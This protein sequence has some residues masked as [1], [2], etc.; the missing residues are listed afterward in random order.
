MYCQNCGTE[1]PE[2]GGFCPECGKPVNTPVQ[3]TVPR[4][5]S[6]PESNAIN[7]NPKPR[8]PRV[9]KIAIGIAAG[10]L[11]LIIVGIALFSFAGS[12]TEPQGVHIP[13]IEE[14]EKKANSIEG[15]TISFE[16][17]GF[18]D[19]FHV[20]MDGN[21]VGEMCLKAHQPECIEIY[22]ARGSSGDNQ[23]AFAQVCVGVIEA[24]DPSLG[25][26]AAKEVAN[27]IV[28]SSVVGNPVECNG[29]AYTP[30]FSKNEYQLSVSVPNE[31][32]S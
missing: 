16:E 21:S 15:G 26:S 7:A 12:S 29:V 24:C 14:I 10:A 31:C 9:T 25:L 20:Y 18:E 6:V 2:G 5:P 11:L 17:G 28:S 27:E 32:V 30:S 3:Q 22:I 23:L 19:T 13:T 4:D 1:I 8:N